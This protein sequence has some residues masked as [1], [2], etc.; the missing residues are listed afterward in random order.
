[1]AKQE[2]QTKPLVNH[3][4]QTLPSL[5]QMLDDMLPEW[6]AG[7][8][9]DLSTPDGYKKLRAAFFRFGEHLLWQLEGVLEKAAGKGISEAL[10][11]VKN[12]DFYKTVKR[13]RTREAQRDKEYRERQERERER[14]ARFEFTE[15]ER[16]REIG[17]ITYWLEY[18]RKQIEELKARKLKVE[19]SVPIMTETDDGRGDDDS[20]Y[21]SF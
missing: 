21:D 1:M 12:P 8:H 3:R 17:N 11:L 7:K 2:T 5:N 15:E 14:R 19:T 10:A 13:R 9:P 4:W 6:P 18:H 16:K 20:S